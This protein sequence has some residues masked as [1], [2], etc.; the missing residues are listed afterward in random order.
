VFRSKRPTI[1]DFRDDYAKHDDFYGVFEQDMKPLY[2]LAFALTANHKESEQCFVST[3]DEAF[4][5]QTVFKEWVRSWVKRRLIENAIE[6]V[7]C[8]TVR[9]GQKRDLWSAT[10]HEK[11]K[12]CEIDT[13][14]QLPSFER[15]VF[16]MSILERYSDWDCSVLLECSMKK[17][18]EARIGAL[19]QLAGFAASFPRGDGLATRR[20]GVTA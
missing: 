9:D 16:V 14:T 8:V 11:E 10:R 1:A 4:K 2:M 3:V 12:P 20:L 17:V 13:V 5:E 18:A 6:N 7:S 19:L 15:S